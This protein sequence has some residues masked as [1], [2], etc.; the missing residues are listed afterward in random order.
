MLHWI[1][2]LSK[3]YFL[4]QALPILPKLT[5]RRGFIIRADNIKVPLLE[6]LINHVVYG[7]LWCPSAR[8]LC[9][10]HLVGARETSK[11]PTRDK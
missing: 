6:H 2:A 3:D 10:P 11:D 5:H 1:L 7:L 8:W 9:S 4:G